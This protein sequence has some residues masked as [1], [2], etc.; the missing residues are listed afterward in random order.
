MLKFNEYLEEQ[1]QFKDGG[2]T[3][4]DI[5]D[6]LFHTTAMIAVTKD[7]KVIKKLSNQ[8]YNTY[9]LKPGEDF[10]YSEFRSAKKFHESKP[11]S[12]MISKAQAIIRNS[13]SN[14]LSKVVVITARANFDD[15]NTFLQM[16]QK[17][18]IDT[19]KV[20]IE[21]AGNIG[22][23]H[24]VAAKKYVIIYNYLNTKQFSRVRLFDD[25]MANLR[26]FLKLQS[27]FPAVKFEA[28][29]AKP[30]GRVTNVKF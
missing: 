24:D 18:G 5:D 29:F 2:L 12:K 15:K 19:N 9:T 10:D 13:E 22:D 23:V 20:R 14:P 4:F 25:S 3:I 11:I 30:D 16:F 6:T 27:T 28:Y 21:R 26:T 8:E 1:T 7:G 17:H